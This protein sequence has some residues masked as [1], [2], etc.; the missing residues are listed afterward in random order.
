MILGSLKGWRKV[1]VFGCLSG[2]AT[3]LLWFGKITSDQWVDLLKWS[4]PALV[5]GNAVE[6]IGER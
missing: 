5:V 4:F 6:H 1:I 2:A 3:V